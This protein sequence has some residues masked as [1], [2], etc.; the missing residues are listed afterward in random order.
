[1]TLTGGGQIVMQTLAGDWNRN[2][3]TGSSTTNAVTLHNV[4]NTI[5]G[6]GWI[7]SGIGVTQSANDPGFRLILDNQASGVIDANNATNGP[8]LT[9]NALTLNMTDAVQNAGTLKA[10]SAGRLYIQSTTI[11]QSGAGMIAANG[12]GSVVIFSGATIEGGLLAA[13]NGGVLEND[14]LHGVTTL[15]GSSAAGAIT[16]TGT[17]LVRTSGIGIPVSASND[18]VLNGAIINK[19]V[20]TLHEAAGDW[21]SAIKIGAGNV[22]LTGGGQIVMQTLVGDSNRNE[23]TGSS[24][25]NAVTLHNVDNTISGAGWIGFGG[26]P[27]DPGFKL[28]LDNQASGVIDANNAKNALTLQMSNAVQNAG[29]LESTAAGGLYIQSTTIAQSGAGM[30]AANGTGSVVIFSGATIEGGLLAATNGGVLENDLLHGVTTLDGSSAAGAITITGTFLV[31]TSGI[32]N[33]VSALND[34]V[35]NGAII[36]KGVL[37]LHEVAG[38]WQS[39]IKIGAGNVTLTG[40]GQIVMQTL[41]GDS[42]RNEITGS[43]ATNAVTLHNVDNLIFGAGWIGSGGTP[44]DPGFKLILDNQAAGTISANNPG[45]ALT[46]STGSAITNNGWLIAAGGTLTVMDS[47]VGAGSAMINGGG[48]MTF[49]A[50]FQESLLFLGKNAGTLNLAQLDL[51]TI[52]GFGAGD[53]I[54]LSY[55]TYKSS[56][57]AVWQA[58]SGV[59]AIEDGANLITAIHLA[60]KYSTSEFIVGQSGSATSITLKGGAALS[61]PL[62]LNGDGSSDLLWRN[63]ATGQLGL[64]NSNGTG[65]FTYQLIG[66]GDP[67][68][69]LQDTG[70][71]NGDGKA[72]LVW[73]NTG[74]GQLGLWNSNGAGGFAYQ[75]ISQ[76]DLN[77]QIQGV[78]DFNGDGNSD[79]LWSNTATGQL[80]LW[81]SNGAGGFTYQTVNQGD[82]TWQI[83][84]TGDFNGDGKS[85]VL[86]RNTVSGQVGIWDNNGTGGFTYQTINQGDLNWQIQGVGDFNGDG[87][88]DM[89]WRNTSTG[90]VGI[91]DSNGSGGFTYQVISQG[92]LNWQ[93]KGVGDFNGDGKSDILWRNTATGQLGIWDTNGTGGFTYQT[94]N[95][96]D[97][98]WNIFNGNDT[99]V[100][101]AANSTLFGNPGNTTFAIGP[102]AG[103]DKIY[104][105]ATSQDTMQFNPA[106]FANFAAAMTHASQVGANTVFAID[107]ND[108]VTLENVSK[109][110]LAASNFRFS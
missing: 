74:S 2:E 18:M 96:G 42:N 69:Q 15:D 41:A 67:T 24:A 57:H 58:G 48:T 88:A 33:P 78:G 12:T 23:I 107:A 93:I 91:W 76:G 32:G 94:I 72:D 28:I 7:G 52:T 108:S 30:I 102:G 14:L 44:N 19:G 34:M 46:L 90:Q 22:T 77:W 16:I 6:A 50:G 25:T 51:G 9:P 37:T 86:W 68:W 10:T 65:G 95:Q 29:T 56:L 85:D 99:L 3:I 103:Q 66:Q 63:A 13:T 1:V 38:D 45:A 17:F 26:T 106:L 55:V 5:S 59:L 20:L 60:G 105:F 110:S 83:Q 84:G 73:R 54:D 27:N 47:V 101:S 49:A 11:A 89:L 64:W 39:A 92:D 8:T 104:N 80:G 71:L 98:S 61:T 87:S 82:L 79:L 53:T 100:A 43:S 97:L 35:L 75:V 31:P 40:G 21:Q 62:D 36:N 4:N 81:Y 70:D 109:N